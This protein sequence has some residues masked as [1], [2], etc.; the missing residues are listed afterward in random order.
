[1]IESLSHPTGRWQP[2][3][4]KRIIPLGI[5]IAAISAAALMPRSPL[6]WPVIITT[7]LSLGYDMSHPLLAGVITSVNPARRGLSMGMN[8]FVLFC[9]FGI[10]TL[11]FTYC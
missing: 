11:V 5:L 1:M 8:A 9:G 3:C 7:I 4:L 10:G 2:N 6:L